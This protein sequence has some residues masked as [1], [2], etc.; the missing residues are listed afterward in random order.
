MRFV[1]CWRYLVCHA[2]WKFS[3]DGNNDKDD[4]KSILKRKFDYK[5]DV[6]KNIS[7]D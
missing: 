5:N 7:D 3:F 2:N 4:Y 6:W 1:E